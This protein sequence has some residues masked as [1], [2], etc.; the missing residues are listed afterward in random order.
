MWP[1]YRDYQKELKV[2]WKNIYKFREAARMHK[3]DIITMEMA[4][5][6]NAESSLRVL[7]D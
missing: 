6:M 4:S 3:N 5:L 7:I 1:P 2:I